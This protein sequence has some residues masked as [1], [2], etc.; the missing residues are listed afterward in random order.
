MQIVDGLCINGE[1]QLAERIYLSLAIF[2]SLKAPG[3]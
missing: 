1:T 3:P 2:M